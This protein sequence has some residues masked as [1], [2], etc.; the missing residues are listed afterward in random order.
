MLNLRVESID[1]AIHDLRAAEIA[2]EIW[3]GEWDTPETGRFA[4]IHVPEGN[5]IELWE[6]PVA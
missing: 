5:T 6:P 1:D 3:R 4:R 2:V